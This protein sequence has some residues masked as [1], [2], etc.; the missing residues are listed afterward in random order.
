[1]AAVVDDLRTL[2]PIDVSWYAPP[3]S[4]DAFFYRTRSQ[5]RYR[6]RRHPTSQALGLSPAA[7]YGN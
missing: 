4:L 6:S 3:V 7:C 2:L 5:P 1:M